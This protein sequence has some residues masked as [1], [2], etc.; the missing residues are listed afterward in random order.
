[1]IKPCVPSQVAYGHVHTGQLV[2]AK[3]SGQYSLQRISARKTCHGIVK[4]WRS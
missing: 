1:M 4:L 3:L 2:C